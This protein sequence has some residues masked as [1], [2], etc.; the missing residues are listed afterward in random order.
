[1][2]VTLS[3]Q[4]RYVLKLTENINRFLNFYEEYSYTKKM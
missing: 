3:K 1:M 4:Y 2:H